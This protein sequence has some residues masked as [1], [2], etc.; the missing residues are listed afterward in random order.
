MDSR[1]CDRIAHTLTMI[2]DTSRDPRNTVSGIFNDAV[3]D[4]LETM[5][6]EL[7]LAKRNAVAL[8]AK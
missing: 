6:D 7:V 2:V 8:T 1:T 4:D 5:R 3:L